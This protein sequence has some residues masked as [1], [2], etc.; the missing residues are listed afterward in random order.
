[1]A[2]KTSSLYWLV[3]LLLSV[4]AAPSHAALPVNQTDIIGRWE[5]G[6]LLRTSSMSVMQLTPMIDSSLLGRQYDFQLNA[7]TV[8]NATFDCK[9]NTSQAKL[10]VP[11]RAL[12][13][14]E[15][16]HRPKLITRPLYGRAKGWALREALGKLANQSITI[17]AYTDCY[18]SDSKAKDGSH[19]RFAAVGD[20]AVAPQWF[21][22]VGDKIL[23]PYTYDALLIL[24][25]PPKQRPPEHVAFCEAAK[26]A[27]DKLICE[28]R[29]MWLMHQYGKHTTACSLDMDNSRQHAETHPYE[30][31]LIKKRDACN[32]ER[33]CLWQALF[34]YNLAVSQNVPWMYKCVNGKPQDFCND[35]LV[36][37]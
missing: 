36:C 2:R 28:D 11:M 22:A 3:T 30:L 4:L 34:N 29:E 8:L 6:S 10:A 32:G 33:N 16:L 31:Q 26:T 14:G 35:N 18:V 12:F 20:A 5:V 17:F 9:L 1:M 37:R 19:S 27:N 24:Q 25:R 15:R 23:I 7:F 21:A 13:E